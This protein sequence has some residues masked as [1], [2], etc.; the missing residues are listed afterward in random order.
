MKAKYKCYIWKPVHLV[1]KNIDLFE[2][3]CLG[4][5]L[6]LNILVAF[7]INKYYIYTSDFCMKFCWFFTWTLVDVIL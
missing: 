6:K 3:I 2:I 5:V 4:G 1:Y 7:L